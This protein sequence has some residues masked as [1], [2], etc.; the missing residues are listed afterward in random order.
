MTT[1]KPDMSGFD[2]DRFQAWE[3]EVQAWEAE[4]RRIAEKRVRDDR[5]ELLVLLRD[6][7]V[8]GIK[9]SYDGYSDSGNVSELCA[10]PEGA[11]ASRFDKRLKNFVWDI[12]VMLH[13]GFE[14]NE[15]G[16]GTLTWDVTNDRIDLDHAEFYTERIPHL[17]EDI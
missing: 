2:W 4:Q 10:T 6:S 13:P 7:G 5:A 1:E 17:H 11:D 16:E 8:T 9:A 14:V 3:A 15:G 12:A